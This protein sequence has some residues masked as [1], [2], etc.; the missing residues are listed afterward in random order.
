[1]RIEDA[2]IYLKLCDLRNIRRTSERLNLTQSAVSKVLQRLEAEF[3][4]ALAVRSP[5]GLILTQE[6]VLLQEKSRQLL[7][8]YNQLRHEMQAARAAHAGQVRVGT[9]PALLQEKFLPLLA[10]LRNNHRGLTLQIKVK[11]SD[12]LI[13]MVSQGELD[14]AV[15]FMPNNGTMSSLQCEPIAT[16]QYHI[17]AR[18]QH[19]L[20]SSSTPDMK[21]LSECEWLLPARTVDMRQWVDQSFI[22]AGL[23]PPATVI[24]T[25]ASTPMYSTLIKQSNIVTAFLSSSLKSRYMD[26]LVELPFLHTTS[27]QSLT[28]IFRRSAY[29]SPAAQQLRTL[30]HRYF[31]ASNRKSH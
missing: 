22:N 11:V 5:E 13:D 9:I 4:V 7:V 15:C 16:E 10:Q 27:E 3:D 26:D 25:D 23:P 28:L 14:L 8:S 24:E 6:G 2:T 29:L 1:M 31:K 18:K 12:E 17:V 20:A 21:A 30:I 19:P